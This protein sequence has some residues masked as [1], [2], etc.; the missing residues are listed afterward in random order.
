VVGCQGR[1]DASPRI[2]SVAADR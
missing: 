2:C 1:L